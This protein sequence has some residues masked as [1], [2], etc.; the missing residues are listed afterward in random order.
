MGKSSS[1]P[2][3][4]WSL[5]KVANTLVNGQLTAAEYV[6]AL[7]ARR[8]AAD[9]AVDAWASFDEGHAIEHAEAADR[10]RE[11]EHRHL[12]LPGI[13]IGV[14]DIIATADMPTEMGTPAFAGNRPG[15]DARCVERLK[16][17]GAFVIGKTVTTELAYM[18]PSKTR[19][20]WNPAHTPGGS[21]SGSAAA[22]AT[23]QVPGA[24][25]TQTNG[26][27]IRPA[28]FCGVVGYKPSSGSIA[29]DGIQPFSP[30]LDQVGVITRSVDDAA[31]L[32]SVLVEGGT[33]APVLAAAPEKPH[34][35]VLFDL[36]WAPAECDAGDLLE[37]AATILRTHVD[38]ATPTLPEACRDT[39][40]VLRTIMMV[41]AARELGAL[42][43]R[44]RDRLSDRLNR[45]LDDARRISEADYRRA[46]DQRDRITEALSQWMRGFDAILMPPA[47][48]GAPATLESTGD[49]SFCTLWSLAGFPAITI[50]VGLDGSRMP[51]GM[52]LA[53]VHGDD[54]RLLALARWCEERLPFAGL[55]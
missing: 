45:D 23:G 41:E 44:A 51:V 52:Q 47:P 27:V 46:L 50:P 17:A 37:H 33:L 31:L 24:I 53:S 20:P 3:H 16:D 43:S 54:S 30:T 19:N 12:P 22:V 9:Q 11:L 35:G 48:G 32:A 40:D 7:I 14:K 38:I 10:E 49:P 1:A 34:L 13:P 28:A 6:K 4:A 26:S 18:H 55:V 25:G 15:R 5:R 2:L 8:N 36:P 21:S 29:L 42:Q 39:R